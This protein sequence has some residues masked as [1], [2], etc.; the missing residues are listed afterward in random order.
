[1]SKS[2]TPYNNK[3]QAH[4]LW[5]RYHTNG[6]L[7]YKRTYNNGKKVGIEEWND[8]SGKLYKKLYHL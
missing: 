8:Y 6:N 4:G 2:I 7:C 1:M 3:R 5:K